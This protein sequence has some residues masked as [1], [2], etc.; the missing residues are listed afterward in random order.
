MNGSKIKSTIVDDVVCQ[1]EVEVYQRSGVYTPLVS[2]GP[3]V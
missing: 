2:E 1:A 3:S